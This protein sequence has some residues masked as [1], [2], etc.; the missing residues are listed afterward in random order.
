MEERESLY[1]RVIMTAMVLSAC[2]LLRSAHSFL[3]AAGAAVF[4][5]GNIYRIFF[6]SSDSRGLRN[7][8]TA[9]CIGI[10]LLQGAAIVN[11]HLLYKE[12]I[13]IGAQTSVLLMMVLSFASSSRKHKGYIE[14][15]SLTLILCCG[16]FI[17][18]YTNLDIFL[19]GVY[20]LAGCLLMRIR[21]Y[22]I[23]GAEDSSASA[24]FNSSGFLA[25]LFVL[26]ISCAGLFLTAKLSAGR[27]LHG[28][29]FADIGEA[30]DIIDPKDYYKLQSVLLDKM[31]PLV[32]EGYYPKD[33][34][35]LLGMLNILVRDDAVLVEVDR[36][37]QGLVSFLRTPGW[38]VEEDKNQ[39]L[40]I[41]KSYIQEKISRKISASQEQINEL[42]K[43]Q[44]PFSLGQRIKQSSLVQE[45][46]QASSLSQVE[47]FHKQAEDFINKSSLFAE[48]VDKAGEALNDIRS[49]KEFEIKHQTRYDA[50]FAPGKEQAP[51]QNPASGLLEPTAP[52]PAQPLPIEIPA[53]QAGTGSVLSHGSLW[54]IAPVF[55]QAF[56][57]LLAVLLALIYILAQIERLN[58]KSLAGQPRQFILRLYAHLRQALFYSRAVYQEILPPL[59]YASKIEQQMDLKDNSLFRLSSKFEEARYSSHILSPED[60]EACLSDYNYFLRAFLRK[61][62]ISTKLVF[63]CRMFFSRKPVSI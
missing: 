29:V 53:P 39:A 17:Q 62:S 47:S 4:L 30:G 5:A 55:A 2:I 28:G 14:I 1:E 10:I 24:L 13:G 16:I 36:A 48:A 12:I 20:L 60:A 61:C 41:L 18:K 21:F 22:R 37:E 44:A 7:L 50:D 51:G 59:Y 49:W 57:I 32:S 58:I 11:S 26:L 40:Q 52:E 23:W 33:K 42:F 45:L 34:L 27:Y 54:A 6:I 35:S 46:K 9:L 8:I 3:I 56:F 43:L 15:L 63:Y 19:L 31:L 38:G 25:M